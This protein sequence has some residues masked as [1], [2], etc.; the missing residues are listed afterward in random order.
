M[1]RQWLRRNWLLLLLLAACII[2]LWVMLLTGSFWTDETETAFIVSRPGDVSLQAAQIPDSVYYFLPRAAERLFGFS[3]V[4][5]R[6][7]SLVLMGIA[8]FFIARLAARLIHPGAAW[9]TVFMCF[10]MTDFNYFAVDA[11][12]YGLGICVTAACMF[13][14][15]RWLDT[16][17]WMPAL[18]F[19]VC[20]ATLW[21]VQLVFWAFYPVFP[22][23]TAIRLARKSAK[24]RWAAIA[25]IY[26]LLALALLPVAFEALALVRTAKSHV[27][28]PVPGV[29]A[30]VHNIG[31]KPVAGSVAFVLAASLLLK[32]WRNE[33]VRFE[34]VAL[35]VA[36]WLWMPVCLW[37]YSNLSGTTLFVPRYFSPSLPGLILA[38][39]ALIALYVPGELWT[40]AAAAMGVLVLITTGHWSVLWPE[41]GGD[42]W[43]AAARAEQVLAREPDTSVITVSP[44]IEAQPPVWKPGYALPAFLYAPL[45]VYPVRGHVFPF[46]FSISDEAE[47]YGA[48]LTQDTL[49]PHRRFLVLGNERVSMPWVEWFSRRPELAGWSY[50]I[51]RFG[52]VDTVAFE[53][54]R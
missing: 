9:F 44:F 14:L 13:F 36:W 2:R 32:R 50:R 37:M 24:P 27:I 25:A 48:R 11:R 43:R 28:L 1:W 53:K 15:V 3:E 6:L 21:R 54:P 5:Y 10:A 23:Y 19:L 42:N 45:F 4:S 7:P 40:R 12:P 26:G 34:S 17:R 29:R 52:T 38:C 49:A 31:W 18:L 16:G 35:I 41:H 51:H 47:E 20:A 8:M 39:V 22:I 33:P 46:P 30:F